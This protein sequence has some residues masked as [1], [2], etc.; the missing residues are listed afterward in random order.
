MGYLLTGTKQ[1]YGVERHSLFP[2]LESLFEQLFVANEYQSVPLLSILFSPAFF[3]W[4]LF[5]LA[6][7]ALY[8]KNHA[9]LLFF[10]LLFGN[11]FNLLFGPCVIIRYAFPLVL[12]CPVLFGLVF[13]KGQTR[14]L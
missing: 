3:T 6:G 14:R 7:Y 12:G 8:S 11:F 1:G 5:F 9:S 10:F 13:Q 2:S 4:L